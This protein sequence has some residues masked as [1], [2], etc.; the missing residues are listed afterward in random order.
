MTY[1]TLLERIRIAGRVARV[2]L[3]ETLEVVVAGRVGLVERELVVVVDAERMLAAP[4]VLLAVAVQ[5]VVPVS[6]LARERHLARAGVDVSPAARYPVARVLIVIRDRDR[7]LLA[8][9]TADLEV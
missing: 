5:I 3:E 1:M 6:K 2:D 4:V 7:Y 9:L 8:L